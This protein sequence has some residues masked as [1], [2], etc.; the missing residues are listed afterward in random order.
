VGHHK[1]TSQTTEEMIVKLEFI[2]INQFLKVIIN[3]MKTH[4]IEC[5]G[6]FTKSYF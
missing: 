6:L 4:L 3:K 1:H 5:D 2:E